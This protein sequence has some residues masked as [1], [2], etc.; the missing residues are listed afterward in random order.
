MAIKKE[1]KRRKMGRRGEGR[2]EKGGKKKKAK[3]SIAKLPQHCIPRCWQ[4]HQ[5]NVPTQGRAE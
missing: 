2:E 1:Q 3:Q 4:E 5:N